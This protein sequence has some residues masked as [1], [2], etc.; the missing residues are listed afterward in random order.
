MFVAN[1]LGFLL[2]PYKQWRALASL[3]VTDYP[4]FLFYPLIMALLAPIAWYYGVTQ[5][6]WTVANGEPIKLTPESGLTVVVLFYLALQLSVLVIGYL[7]HWMSST[8]QARTSLAKGVVI[9]SFVAT[10]LY[11]AGLVGFYPILWLDFSVGVVALAWSIFL[12]Y[13]GIPAAMELPKE[14]GFLYAS[15]VAGVAM[16]MLICIDRKSVV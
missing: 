2:N 16:V 8:Y 10:P 13:T 4:K 6:G 14:Q 3:P 15:A 11:L 12:L 5:V 7:T 9:V 1:P